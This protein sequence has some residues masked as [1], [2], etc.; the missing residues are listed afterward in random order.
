MK[1]EHLGLIW[2]GSNNAQ[3]TCHIARYNS[4]VHSP[5]FVQHLL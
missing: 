5:L 1:E 4:T 3:D 2:Y